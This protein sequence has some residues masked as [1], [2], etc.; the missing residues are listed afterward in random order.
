MRICCVLLVLASCTSGP[1]PRPAELPEEDGPA[2][3]DPKHGYAIS[4]LPSF[5]S[6]HPDELQQFRVVVQ[7]G[8]LHLRWRLE[9]AGDPTEWGTIDENGLYRAPSKPPRGP[10]QVLADVED[11]GRRIGTVGAVVEVVRP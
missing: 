8:D 2:L 7:G 3:A 1:P 9:G 11:R 6:R 10:V 4:I 5:V